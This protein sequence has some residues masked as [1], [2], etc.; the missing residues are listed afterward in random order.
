MREHSGLM[1]EDH[2]EE[3]AQWHAKGPAEIFNLGKDRKTDYRLTICRHHKA[4][5]DS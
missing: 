5:M 4:K 2:L 1:H 3:G